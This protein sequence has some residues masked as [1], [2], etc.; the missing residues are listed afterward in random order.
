MFGVH[1]QKKNFYSEMEE[2]SGG[3]EK[4]ENPPASCGDPC[5]YNKKV[6]GLFYAHNVL[7]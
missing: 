1:L 7:G 3:I 2:L 5:N 6:C 4:D